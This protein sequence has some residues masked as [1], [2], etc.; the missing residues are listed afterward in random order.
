MKPMREFHTTI[1]DKGQRF[2]TTDT[3][4]MAGTTLRMNV[5]APFAQLLAPCIFSAKATP[6]GI[7]LTDLRQLAFL[8][9]SSGPLSAH[10]ATPG[11]GYRP[12]VRALD[13]S[14]SE[15]HFIA[16]AREGNRKRWTDDLE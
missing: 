16:G 11:R 14:P 15:K 4:K 1:E 10:A 7:A 13:S 2:R 5:K 12:I 3:R 9:D 6:K 8:L